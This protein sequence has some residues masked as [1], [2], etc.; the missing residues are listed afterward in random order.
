[1]HL[2]PNPRNHEGRKEKKN[3]LFSEPHARSISLPSRSHPTISQIQNLVLWLR[4]IDVTSLSL[5]AINFKLSGLGDLFDFFDKFL[6]LPLTQQALARECNEKWADELLDGL[7]LLLD[8]C[9]NAK[10]ILSQAKQHIQ[11]LQSMLRRRWADE[12]EL[13]KEIE[14]DLASRKKAKK[15]IH[16]ALKDLIKNKFTCSISDKGNDTMAMVEMSRQIQGLALTMLQ[17]LLFYISGLKTQSK[18]RSWTLVSKYLMRSKHVACSVEEAIGS[19]E[20]EVDTA[21]QILVGHKTKKSSNLE[22]EN[23][24]TELRKLELRM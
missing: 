4:P 19:N 2:N 10:D 23:V 20:F 5:S 14:E 16:K 7:L 9:G 17:S 8:V 18:L 11:E 12:F 6:L 24:K 22:I 1:M 13:E 3:D 15:V 21:L